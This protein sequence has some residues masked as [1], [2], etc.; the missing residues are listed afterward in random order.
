[1]QFF[2][3]ATAAVAFLPTSLA[4]INNAPQAVTSSG[5]LIGHQA[6]N[7]TFVSE[8]L[9]VRYAQAPTGDL[10]F[11]PPKRYIV[12]FGTVYQAKE[13]SDDCLSN[14]PP[15]SSFPNFSQPSGL[16]TWKNFAGQ[17]DNP[18]SE[19][20]LKLN[21]WAKA[22][23][24]WELKPVLVYFHGG[25]FITP[26]PHSPF[27]N[28]Q[29]LADVEDVVVVTVNYRLGI[30][31]FSGA[32]GIQ[33]NIA[34]LDQ[35]LA[36]TWVR[37]NIQAFGGDPKRIVIFGQSAGGASVDYF[38]FAYKSDPIVSGLIA[39][40]GTSLRFKPNS[41]EYAQNLWY[42]VTET[43]DCGTA[44][45]HAMA[46]LACV[47]Q[48]PISVV[49]AAA[50]KVQA[51][52]TMALAK[53]AFYPTVDNVTVFANYDE[54][55]KSGA[56]AEIPLL[57]G[58]TDFEAGWYKLSAYGAKLN[59]SE[60]QWDLFVERGF[61]CPNKYSTKARVNAGVPTWRYRYHG[62]WDNL[63]LYDSEAGL[64][65][66]GSGAYH[67]SE[68]GMIFG[69]AQDIS[70]QPNTAEEE[71]TS[72][73]MMGAWAA[74][75]RDSREGLTKYGWPAYSEATESLVR[76][77]Y[78]NKAALNVVSPSLYDNACPLTNDGSF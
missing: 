69:T 38:S 21:V 43:I 32:P 40:S 41:P 4:F 47:R 54:L 74:F 73:Y 71:A 17:N 5:T 14:K 25:R 51:L 45:D 44:N 6:S 34:L 42:N 59:L 65:P 70:G 78:N 10:R 1:M 48:A 36:V 49:L 26:G 63:R 28:G 35:R 7:K 15:L 9:G 11:A 23:L 57:A 64:G 39:H 19:D 76:L 8:Y 16:R 68:I 50:A 62:D 27:Y 60:A 33:Q 37:D 52:P 31:G 2:Y 18:A 77:G 55:T 22:T 61:T 58:N 12:P 66:R 53:A 24:W 30:F 46:V 29:Y 56:F 75:A 13:W 72:R 3:T 67:G 20:C